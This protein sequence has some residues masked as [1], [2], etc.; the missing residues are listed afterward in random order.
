MKFIV[1][2][3]MFVKLCLSIELASVHFVHFKDN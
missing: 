3:K 2:K 1:S